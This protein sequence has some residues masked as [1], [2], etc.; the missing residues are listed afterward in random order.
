[1]T[2]LCMEQC[3]DFKFCVLDMRKGITQNN[4]VLGT[5]INGAAQEKRGNKDKNDNKKKKTR[6]K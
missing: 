2:S 3:K 4:L 1:M 6:G 5:P